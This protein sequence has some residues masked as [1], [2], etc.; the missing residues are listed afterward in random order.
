MKRLFAMMMCMFVLLTAV[1]AF[2]DGG[3]T[4]EKFCNVLLDENFESETTTVETVTASNGTAAVESVAEGAEY[5]QGKN[6]F[7]IKRTETSV[8]SG[9][10]L[11]IAFNKER[12]FTET[13]R[14]GIHKENTDKYGYTAELSFDWNPNNNNASAPSSRIGI[15]GRETNSATNIGQFMY[16]KY[17]GGDKPASGRTLEIS[18]RSGNSEK[19]IDLTEVLGSEIM[20]S[21]HVYRVRLVLKPFAEIQK[22][23][24]VDYAGTID[25]YFDGTFLYTLKYLDNTKESY[26]YGLHYTTNKPDAGTIDNIKLTDYWNGLS[27][28]KAYINDDALITAVRRCEYN[29][30]NLSGANYQM[31]K[32][33]I[34]AA[35]AECEAQERTQ[36][37]VDEAKAKLAAAETEA[38]KEY[39][40]NALYKETYEENA[41]SSFVSF[42]ESGDAETNKSEVVS[43][44]SSSLEYF[45]LDGKWYALKTDDKNGLYHQFG[46][47][48]KNIR[49]SSDNYKTELSFDYRMPQDIV[50]RILINCNQS[51]GSFNKGGKVLYIEM[52][53]D[54]K[55]AA[56][57]NRTDGNFIATVNLEDFETGANF[58]NDVNRFRFVF[59]T[60][61]RKVS[62][63]IN[64]I[65]ATEIDYADNEKESA[66]AGMTVKSYTSNAGKAL[67]F[68]DNIELIDYDDL[69]LAKNGAAYINKD[70]LVAAKSVRQEA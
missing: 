65:K 37:S 69:T 22:V 35:K 60:A 32:D 67:G 54:S 51:N 1:P 3:E 48:S 43:Q 21:D 11:Q 31:L 59:D 53:P 30:N 33:A 23:D 13:L 61:N 28:G 41:H 52:Y 66:I 70:K 47:P 45:G 20:D 9:F 14:G 29:L 4:N 34:A 55:T 36:Q 49:T 44:E 16:L 25:I 40:Y 58:V 19:Q 39:K 17:V 15:S 38:F 42:T 10:Y 57:A 56:I 18:N 46:E 64:G 2:A 12:K 63:L 6:N 26:I 62:W 7:V 27:S 5:G 24:G 8:D 68:I 50:S